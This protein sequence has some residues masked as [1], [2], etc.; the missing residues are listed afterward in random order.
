MSHTLTHSGLSADKQLAEFVK[1]QLLPG[2]HLDEHQF[3]KSFAHIVQTLTPLMPIPTHC[4][5]PSFLIGQQS[6]WAGGAKPW[7]TCRLYLQE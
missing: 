4:F 2:T 3:W 7:S 5:H 1:K 6:A